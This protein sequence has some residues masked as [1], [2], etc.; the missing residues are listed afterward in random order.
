[1]R[2]R[3]TRDHVVDDLHEFIP[4]LNLAK[5]FHF[6]KYVRKYLESVFNTR[7]IDKI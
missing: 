2:L 5:S 1:M 6:T 3:I 7:L 4:Y